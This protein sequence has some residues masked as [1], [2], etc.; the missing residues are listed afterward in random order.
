MK[1]EKSSG[2]I[3][4]K[5]VAGKRQYL[6]LAYPGMTDKE[7][8][9]WGF[10]KGHV[11]A[12]ESDEETAR[13]EIGEETGLSQYSFVEGFKEKENYLFKREG[14][15]VNK[16]S[17]YFLAR[18][19]QD[20]VKISTEHLGF[21][22]LPLKEALKRLTFKNAKQLLQKAEDFLSNSSVETQPS[23]F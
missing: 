13:R 23:L 9:Y 8:I 14:E 22:W 20:E 7:K 21:E 18:T 16:T 5:E 11:D 1:Y 17:V 10:P 19:S 6:L 2:A 3:I 12:G 15:L 4:F